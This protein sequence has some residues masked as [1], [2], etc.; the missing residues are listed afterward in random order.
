MYYI[1]IDL[2]GTN[3]VCGIVD[4]SGKLLMKKSCKTLALRKAEEIMADMASLCLELI[5]EFGCTKEKI[6]FCGI[7]CPGIANCESGVLEYSCN[8]PSFVDFDIVTTVIC[9]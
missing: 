1:G 6:A 8:L 3:I 7:A 4:V 9:L 2:G 5:D